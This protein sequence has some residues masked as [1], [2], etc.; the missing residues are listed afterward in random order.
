MFAPDPRRHQVIMDHMHDTTVYVLAQREPC[1]STGVQEIDAVKPSKSPQKK[2]RVLKPIRATDLARLRLAASWGLVI[3]VCAEDDLT[4]V[5][6]FAK[7]MGPGWRDRIRFYHHPK[8]DL[9]RAFR[10]W[11]K[12][13]LALPL[14][15]RASGFR[16]LHPILGRAVNEWIYQDHRR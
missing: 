9:D 11:I 4:L 1:L 6:A 3:L 7:N 16:E 10:P 15:E 12:A 13:G 5:A 14:V 8:V 2:G